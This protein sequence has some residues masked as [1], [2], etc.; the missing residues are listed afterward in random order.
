MY[1][2]KYF[3]QKVWL[4]VEILGQ[5]RGFRGSPVRDV[6]AE[7]IDYA[8]EQNS[9][10]IRVYSFLK[11]LPPG[12][13]DGELRMIGFGKAGRGMY[14]GAKKFFGEKIS[15]AGIILPLSEGEKF[16][17][18]FLPG[19][20]PLLGKESIES[21][22]KILELLSGLTK[23]D[24]V[25]VLISGGGSSLFEIL[26]EGVELS[27]Y[28]ETVNCLMRNGANIK[29]L[30]A[31]RYLYSRTK[32]GGLLE[33]TH[34]ARVRGLIV[35]DVPGDNEETVASGPTS[36]P[37]ERHLIESVIAKYGKMC[38]LP[39]AVQEYRR[40]FYRSENY[41]VLRNSDFVK[42]IVHR[43]E[44]HGLRGIDV[45]SGIEGNTESVARFLVDRMRSE[46][47]KTNSPVTV[48]GGGETF[49]KR[50]GN[51][52][53]G[54]NLELTLRV[55]L[56]MDKD[57]EFAF[58]S[59]GTDGM[60]GSSNAMGAIVDDE[61]LRILD[62]KLILDSLSRSESLSPLIMSQDVLFT[63]PTGTNVSDIFVGYYAGTG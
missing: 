14:R 20:H 56:L 62:R 63:G 7:S 4:S 57:E 23:D 60:D 43:V 31:A 59:I 53:G 2:V 25:I 15:R 16:E 32:G 50:I 21:S 10:D 35:S 11:Q 39:R 38:T 47:R 40:S 24:V 29:E 44:H 8:F 61:T 48:V 27:R 37:P 34:P 41:V 36:R 1:M 42:S 30:N 46:Y 51:G 22:K 12:D 17:P 3:N 26:R 5:A 49:T 18:P 54:R 6:L 19:N 9:P 28:N 45:G 13:L 55:L 58:G 33:F 52:R